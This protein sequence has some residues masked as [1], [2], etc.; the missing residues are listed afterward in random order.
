[1]INITYRNAKTIVLTKRM[2]MNYRFVIPSILLFLI[3]G[4]SRGPVESSF[5]RKDGE[6]TLS[7]LD[8]SY[9][10]STNLSHLLLLENFEMGKKSHYEAG[11]VPFELGPWRLDNALIELQIPTNHVIRVQKKGMVSMLFDV[12]INKTSAISI[13]HGVYGADGRSTWQLWVSKNGGDTYQQIGHTITSE[14]NDFSTAVFPLDLTGSLRF[15]IRKVSGGNNRILFD[16]FAITT[17][18]PLLDPHKRHPE[19]DSHMLLGN[20]NH[21][22][23]SIL[24]PNKYLMDK[25]YY[26]VSYNSSA[27]IP[28]WV[29]WHLDATNLGVCKR[30]GNF[31]ADSTLPVSWNTLSSASY[32]G[33]GFDRG[34]SCP[35]ADRTSADDANSSTFLMTNIFPQ[36]PRN[37]RKT[38]A[39]FEDYLRQQVRAGNE[40]YVIMGS[41]GKG[42]TGD[43]GYRT[44]IVKDGIHITVPSRIWKVAVVIPNGINDLKRIN[45]GT[46]VIAIDAPN[47]LSVDTDWRSYLTSVKSIED[48][49]GYNIMSNVHPSIQAILEAKVDDQF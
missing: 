8:N 35:S 30:K 17:Y 45:V 23:S 5:S 20:P 39:K 38:W 21:S 36:S 10:S 1:M 11:D 25:K 37:N 12:A 24:F 31:I 28:N 34:H 43:K 26:M 7:T 2:L 48:S 9:E 33:S 6:H 27:H 18:R 46:R 13:K 44:S 16:D 22:E 29:S 15:E 42:G 3:I 40:A 32:S 49:T 41:Y 19:D 4:C 47:D 14:K